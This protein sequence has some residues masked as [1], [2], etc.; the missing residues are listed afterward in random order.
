MAKRKHS[1][2]ESLDEEV[3]MLITLA[4]A[5]ETVLVDLPSLV[6]MLSTCAGA[7]PDKSNW[8][9]SSIL[10]DGKP[11]T[12]MVVVAWLNSAYQ[13]IE[14][15]DYDSESEWPSTAADVYQLLAY[16]DAIGTKQP[17]LASIALTVS[18]TLCLCAELGGCTEKLHPSNHCFFSRADSPLNLRPGDSNARCEED[19][20]AFLK[21]V[22]GQLEQLL[23]IA[24]KLEQKQLLEVLAGYVRSFVGSRNAMLWHKKDTIFSRRVL[25]AAAGTILG[26]NS[27]INALATYKLE[28]VVQF[29]LTPEQCSGTVC[30]EGTLEADAFGKRKGDQV[31]LRLSNAGLSGGVL[32][33]GD[34]KANVHLRVG[35]WV[36][37]LE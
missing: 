13:H 17:L 24:V 33:I 37:E 34:Y 18:E 11:V 22:A 21:A 20:D 6:C 25:D 12:R 26:Q 4:D 23:Y 32:H 14:G 35:R 3:S 27:L 5:Q 36:P 7:L 30:V 9:L 28:D 31:S 19:K 15:R 16:S 2:N 8:D 10:I 29:H 1:G